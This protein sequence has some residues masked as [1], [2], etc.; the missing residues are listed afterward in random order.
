MQRTGPNR[1]E[2]PDWRSPRLSWRLDVLVED[3]GWCQ[4]PDQPERKGRDRR[5]IQVPEDRDETRDDVDGDREVDD[6]R[7]QDGFRMPRY[8]GV[9][10]ESPRQP[11]LGGLG[12]ER[13]RRPVG[14]RQNLTAR[15]VP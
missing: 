1:R 6:E 9:T 14:E 12:R 4:S 15:H 11:G 7:W 5:I 3:R 10:Q 2:G 13:R 8:A